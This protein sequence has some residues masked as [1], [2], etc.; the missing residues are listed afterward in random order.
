MVIPDYL[1][2][3]VFNVNGQHA[4]VQA[5]ASVQDLQSAQRALS[6]E[7][8]AA[9]RATQEATRAHREH[10]ARL[11][12]LESQVKNNILSFKNMASLLAGGLFAQQIASTMQALGAQEQLKNSLTSLIFTNASNVDSMGKVIAAQAKWAL[13]TQESAQAYKELD[14]IQKSTKFNLNDLGGMFKSFYSTASA[15]MGLKDALKVMEAIA[16]AAQVSGADVNSLKATLDSLG[17]GSANTA[18]DF[19][20]FVNALGLTTEAMKKARAEGNLANLML[21]KMGQFKESAQFSAGSW[22]EVWSNFKNAI[23]LV[24]ENSLAPYF[25]QIKKSFAGWTSYL[26]QHQESLKHLVKYGLDFVKVLSAL[27]AGLVAYKIQTIALAAST[28]LWLIAQNA[29]TGGITLSTL[30]LR[31]MRAAILRLG[32]P[33]LIA[34]LTELWLNFDQ[35][36]KWMQRAWER[37]LYAIKALWHNVITGL[38]I[39]L[40]AY[41]LFILDIFSSLLGKLN[42][43]LGRFAPN[44]LKKSVESLRASKKA[45]LAELE[46]LKHSFKDFSA[47]QAPP[48]P[49]SARAHVPL[50]KRQLVYTQRADPQALEQRSEALNRALKEIARVGMS[51]YAR[52]IEQIREKTAEWIKAGVKSTIALKAQTRALQ[53]LAQ[54]R[55]QAQ[56]S[57]HEDFVMSLEKQRASLL[58]SGPEQERALEQAR[59]KES[60]AHLKREME[61]KMQAHAISVAEANEAYRL[62]QALH[63]QKMDQIEQSLEASKRA[64]QEQAEALELDKAHRYV[65]TELDLRQRAI[66]LS[67][68]GHAKE[69]ALENLRYEQAIHNLNA[70]TT[71]RLKAGQMSLDQIN[72]L[73]VA[74]NQAHAK[75]L[76]VLESEESKGRIKASLKSIQ[77]GF[78]A[79]DLSG[80]FRAGM[81]RGVDGLKDHLTNTLSQ[82]FHQGFLE[83]L[84][85][86]D[87]QKAFSRFLGEGA[88]AGSFLEK[89][90]AQIQGTFAQLGNMLAGMGAGVA[91]GSLVGGLIDTQGDRAAQKRMQTGNLI[92]SATG[93]GIGA[94]LTPVMG[95]LGP[96][97]GGLFGGVFGTLIGG[98]SS[99]KTKTEM[100]SKGIEFFNNATS[101]E[102]NAKFFTDM[103]QTTTRSTWWGLV[104]KTST[105]Y[106]SEY[107]RVGSYAS[108]QIKKSLSTYEGLVED[109]TGVK[110]SFSIQA[111]R[112]ESV[113][114]AIATT[115]NGLIAQVME[116]P[117]KIAGQRQHHVWQVWQDRDQDDWHTD[118][119]HGLEAYHR[120]QI[121]ANNVDG[122]WENLIKRDQV[123]DGAYIEGRNKYH[124]IWEFDIVGTMTNPIINQ[125]RQYWQDY[126]NGLKR[127]INAVVQEV[128]GNYVKKGQ[129][130][131]AW[132][133][134]FRGDGVG[135]AQY[136]L[137]LFKKQKRRLLDQLGLNP[138]QDIDVD[139]FLN[140]RKQKIKESMDPHTIELLNALGDSIMQ[141][142][143]ASK[144]LQEALKAQ[145]QEALKAKDAS[146]KL[147]EE[148]DKEAHRH[149]VD[150]MLMR[151]YGQDR[152]A[153]SIAARNSDPINLK[154]LE[155]LQ[156][157]LSLAR[158]EQ[159]RA[160]G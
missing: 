75:A 154:I 93:A 36:T 98:F 78:N 153:V 27:A 115:I 152:R 127:D 139:S 155:T 91:T 58:P 158:M 67:L 35:V 29:L 99:T 143:T 61:A 105:K 77:G 39:G 17:A 60:L 57:A 55:K 21:E 70:E 66:N 114:G 47:P 134:D 88:F 132:L 31:A 4:L 120:M 101:K 146:K 119:Y 1:F 38:K 130:F 62:A 43:M 160:G 79:L 19:G 59:Y 63:K 46:G 20:R 18:T 150:L 116:I 49:T 112:Y 73:Y 40:N 148:Y 147:Q 69:R 100:V 23:N 149:Y 129:E 68:E 30:A 118:G 106:W 157:M 95:P 108:D 44:F 123:R 111:G 84:L 72:R 2:N 126:A 137:D 32:F 117:E 16:Q 142:A 121:M 128:M 131:E 109:I 51:E 83:P 97:V 25:E 89:F 124:A 11:K 86:G 92:G 37:T 82:S 10:Q 145:G 52:K 125:V 102:I 6:V 151:T 41:A 48:H 133:Y 7:Q 96:L 107:A 81:Q 87:F 71:A 34:L 8:R 26:E 50:Q 140:F 64:A 144:Q 103:K 54:E 9:Q 135:K 33:A 94:A 65:Q 104:K 45:Y 141:T 42:N 122:W 110:T 156:R 85:G 13:S 3:V 136:M 5:Q 24:K 80:A 22:E 28:R 56:A 15:S 12:D 138:T 113:S 14:R 159:A 74:E 90:S 53:A 76:L